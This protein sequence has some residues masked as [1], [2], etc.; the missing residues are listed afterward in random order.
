LR[1]DTFDSRQKSR[2]IGGNGEAIT[3]ANGESRQASRQIGGIQG[4]PSEGPNGKR[5]HVGVLK[6][7]E[8]RVSK[9]VVF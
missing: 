9:I 2:Q 4:S 8:I 6:K 3:I 7:Y 1:H 5:E